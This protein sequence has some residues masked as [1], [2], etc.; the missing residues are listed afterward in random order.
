[1]AR[2]DWTEG[3]LQHFSLVTKNLMGRDLTLNT[4]TAT[5]NRALLHFLELALLFSSELSRSHSQCPLHSLSNTIV[6]LLC[7]SGP[8]EFQLMS[9]GHQEIAQKSIQTPPTRRSGAHP[10][11]DGES[12]V[13]RTPVLHKQPPALLPK[14]FNRLPNHIAGE[15]RPPWMHVDLRCLR[16]G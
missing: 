7:H 6:C 16:F 4:S 8:A 14:P 10:A 12:M 3:E 15:P 9:D 11:E 13:S 5:C 1:M 2:F